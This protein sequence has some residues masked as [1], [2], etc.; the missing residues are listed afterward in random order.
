MGDQSPY[1]EI[2]ESLRAD[3]VWRCH[4]CDATS[5]GTP[6]EQVARRTLADHE[7]TFEH[8]RR[9]GSAPP[10]TNVTAAEARGFRRA[11][12]AL[13]DPDG[14]A[15]WRMEL[16]SNNVLTTWTPADA[17]NAAEYLEHLAAQDSS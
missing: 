15:Q 16:W 8:R 17:V 4:P 1:V 12:E 14:Y 3:W 13:R 10:R 7:G 6:D 9:V 2:I 5:R 11:I